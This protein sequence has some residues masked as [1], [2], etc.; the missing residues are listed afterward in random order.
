MCVCLRQVVEICQACVA[1]CYVLP[2]AERVYEPSNMLDKKDDCDN[3]L[4]TYSIETFVFRIM[5][6]AVP[7]LYT[8]QL[9]AVPTGNLTPR[10]IMAS[11]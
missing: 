11:V 4:S 1:D 7:S 3:R 10:L 8:F 6:S 5:L 2:V 9:S